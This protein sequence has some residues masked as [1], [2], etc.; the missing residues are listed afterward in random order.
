MGVTNP[1]LDL[2]S[3][4]QRLGLLLAL[5]AILIV[6]AQ[7]SPHDWRKAEGWEYE[8][9]AGSLASGHGYTFDRGTAWLGPYPKDMSFIPTAWVE[10]VHTGIIAAA[11][12]LFGKGGRLALVL[13]NFIWVGAACWVV[14][15]LVDRMVGPP[16]GM[17]TAV[18][19]ALFPFDSNLLLYNIGNTSIASFVIIICAF[20]LIRC[21]ERVSVAR[22]LALGAMI[23]IANLTHTSSLLFAPLSA[24]VLL[25][26]SRAPRLERLKSASLVLI[27]AVCVVAPWTVR[28]YLTFDRLV[29]VRDGL[30]LHLHIGNPGL[31]QT[32][33]RGLRIEGTDKPP[34]WT[35]K[36]PRQSLAK[37][38]DLKHRR[39]LR[40]HSLELVTSRAPADY[41]LFNEVQ[42]D[43]VFQA[44]AKAFMR[45]HPVLVAKM[46]FWKGYTFL[47]NGGLVRTL[48]ALV[49]VLGW[50]VMIRDIRAS[51]LMLFLL[52]YSAPY[53]LSLPIPHRYRVPAEPI[54]FV[55]IGCFLGVLIKRVS[56]W[57]SA[58]NRKLGREAIVTSQ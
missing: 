26:G 50:L 34:P 51:I 18:L 2:S 15:L 22:S 46:M 35:A 38:A 31:A 5:F 12:R 9:V 54:V 1:G 45:D 33:T 19:L 14:F 41:Q 6:R 8:W 48:T 58:R 56:S 42:R 7:L 23:G 17:L 28:N 44:R 30:G 53:V 25:L 40:Y 49:A 27:T 43:Q 4:R 13:L 32:F 29:V 52:A 47:T 10:P 55:L 20:L 57:I 16:A 11:S 36:G 37:L 21:L 3:R 24:V 39:A